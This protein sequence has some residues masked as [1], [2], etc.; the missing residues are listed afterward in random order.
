MLIDEFERKLANLVGAR[1]ACS[2]S[3][4]TLSKERRMS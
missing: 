1:L 4:C 3:A 2:E